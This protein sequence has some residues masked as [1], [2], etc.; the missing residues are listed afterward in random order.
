MISSI[1][2]ISL[3]SFRETCAKLPDR[4][5]FYHSTLGKSDLKRDRNK[6]ILQKRCKLLHSAT[7][8]N[9]FDGMEEM[10]HLS[11]VVNSAIEN[12]LRVGILYDLQYSVPHLC[13]ADSIDIVGVMR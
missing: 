10:N 1:I 2:A 13:S 3:A 9:G 8:C 11:T 6:S 7:S 12:L 4:E 5:Q